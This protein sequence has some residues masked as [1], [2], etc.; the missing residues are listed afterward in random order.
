MLHLD[1]AYL[2][3][4]PEH[5]STSTES[6]K[7]H[8][9]GQ[10]VSSCK[11]KSQCPSVAS[12]ITLHTVGATF[13]ILTTVLWSNSIEFIDWVV[14]WVLLGAQYSVRQVQRQVRV[15]VHTPT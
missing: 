5:A 9:H 8:R 4:M 7:I 6:L 14:A 15:C 13:L 12:S 3:V 1:H 11:A 2:R 10:A